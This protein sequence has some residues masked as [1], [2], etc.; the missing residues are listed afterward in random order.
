MERSP[1]HQQVDTLPDLLRATIDPFVQ[2][3]GAVLPPSLCANLQ[4]VF[5]TGCGDSHHAAVNAELAFEELAG[6]PCEALTAM[7][8]SRYK[9]G[10]LPDTGRGTNL[11]L[12]VSVSGQVS[13]TVEALDLA[14]RAGATAV[15]VTASPNSPL[16]E[17]ARHVLVTSVP[18]LPDE[19]A[20]LVVPGTR[21]YVASQ[22]ALYLCAI[23]IGQQRGHLAPAKANTLRREV[24]GAAD[25]MEQ[26][27]A[28]DDPVVRQTAE[29]WR[30]AD[31]FVYCGA[32]P[33]YG[34]ALFSAAK[35]LEA[36]GD[37][38]IARDT[39]EWAHLEYFAR[40]A[41]TPTFL[42][43]AGGGDES[44][45][46]EVAVAAQSIG[47]RVAIIAPIN[48]ALAQ[49]R[50]KDVLLPLAGSIRECFSP[51]LACLPGTLFAA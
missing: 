40:E 11:V 25:L 8:F 14:R 27:I 37:V 35:L 34:T 33:N 42:I 3:I 38:A 15:A 4:R 50:H 10:Y 19:L 6:L 1:L 39:E 44:R 22:L 21:S 48:S 5:V 41:A 26:T 47:R 32:G 51:L 9:A 31:H 24:A 46:L 29:A 20:G 28:A 45:A 18:P 30:E 2:A 17:V 36:S 23:H 13:R 43:S 7:H 16:A 12:A 49:S